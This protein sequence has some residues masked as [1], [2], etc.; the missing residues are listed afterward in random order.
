MTSPARCSSTVSPSRT[1]LRAIS[2]SLCRVAFV[3]TTPPT[4][5]GSSRATGVSE[6]VRPTWISIRRS[7]VV[8]RSAGNLCATAQR[9]V[10][11]MKPSRACS[12]TSFTL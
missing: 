9:G 11:E 5:T 12:A 4:V 10:R 8:A 3:T 7:T 1:S 2:S 6:P